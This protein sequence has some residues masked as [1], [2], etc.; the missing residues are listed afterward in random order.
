LHIAHH[1][2][3]LEH[4]NAAYENMKWSGMYELEGAIY[5]RLGVTYEYLG[6]KDDALAWYKKSINHA[7]RETHLLWYKSLFY[8]TPLL[9]EMGRTEEAITILENTTRE[10]PPIT[11]WE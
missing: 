1:V 2:E 10:F 11:L 7:S 5:T 8:I 6:K 4:I 3:A 9:A